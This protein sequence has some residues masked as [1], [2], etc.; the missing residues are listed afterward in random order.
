M[1]ENDERSRE[2]RKVSKE[3]RRKMTETTVER[4]ALKEPERE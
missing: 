1:R 4:D 2:R 3:G